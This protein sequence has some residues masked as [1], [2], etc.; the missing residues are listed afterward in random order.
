MSTVHVVLVRVSASFPNLEPIP[1][2]DAEEDFAQTITSG[3]SSTASTIATP[4]DPTIR[5]VWDVT[6][7]DA[8]IWVKFGTTPIAAAGSGYLIK[9]GQFRSFPARSGGQKIAVKDA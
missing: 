3:A 5:R 1:L 9:A 6:A 8:D 2:P 4:T 7:V